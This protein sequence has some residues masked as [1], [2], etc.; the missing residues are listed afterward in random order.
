MKKTTKKFITTFVVVLIISVMLVPFPGAET[1]LRSYYSGDVIEYNGY[2]V[3]ATTNS[4]AL[5]L[6][7]WREGE[8]FTKIASLKSVN[9]RFATFTDYYST[10]LHV[11]DGD[12]FV[13]AVDG[14]QIH[15]YAVEDLKRVKLINKA[16]DAMWDWFGSLTIVDDR[17]ASTGSKGIKIWNRD[18]QV[19]DSYQIPLTADNSFNVTTAGSKKYLFNVADSKVSILDRENRSS[20]RTVPIQFN[21]NSQ[22]YKRSIYN[23]KNDDAIYVV[24]DEALRKINLRGEIIKSF[25]HTG[26]TGFDVIPSTDGKNIYF[27]DGIGMVTL[28]KSDLKVMDYVYSYTLTPNGGWTMGIKSVMTPKGERIVVF[29]SNGIVILNSALNLV[30]N[31][32]SLTIIQPT[33]EDNSPIINE[34]LYLKVDKN[35]VSRNGEVVLHGGG[36][37]VDEDLEIS[38]G[39]D[40][41]MTVVADDEGK[42]IQVIT[43][44]ANAP[45]RKDLKV[46]GLTSHLTYS[47]GLQIE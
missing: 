5:E 36:F 25:D 41:I 7:K 6:F 30:K 43:V 40:K 46:K 1:R 14:Q 4:G 31:G 47:L 24:D 15:K 39:N 10:V 35:R 38:L 13:Y 11:E 33:V 17:V 44:A 3:V 45:A 9:E 12:L 16:Q 18:L 42:F 34:P 22:W 19:I 27:S 29:N 28:R 20:V 37:A 8:N 32:N 26:T 23:D 2:V 21:W